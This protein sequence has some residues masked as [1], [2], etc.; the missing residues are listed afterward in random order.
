MKIINILMSVAI[1][2]LVSVGAANAAWTCKVLNSKNTAF[3]GAGPDRAT[4]LSTAIG[5][6]SKR[7]PHAKNCTI[8]SCAH[9]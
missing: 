1:L 4:A 6:C 7:T 3:S 2:S 8:Q 9:E 5:H